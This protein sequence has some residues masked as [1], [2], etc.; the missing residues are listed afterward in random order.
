MKTGDTHRLSID[1]QNPKERTWSTINQQTEQERNNNEIKETMKDEV[2]FLEESNMNLLD[3]LLVSQNSCYVLTEELRRCQQSN[4]NILEELEACQTANRILREELQRMDE[5]RNRFIKENKQYKKANNLLREEVRQLKS[6]YQRKRHSLKIIRENAKLLENKLENED[7]SVFDKYDDMKQALT[8][9]VSKTDDQDDNMSIHS[10]SDSRDTPQEG[11]QASVKSKETAWNDDDS[12]QGDGKSSTISSPRDTAS[13]IPSPR[14]TAS[15]ASSPRGIESLMSSPRSLENRISPRSNTNGVSKART[16]NSYFLERE[17][18]YTPYNK[19]R[20]IRTSTPR[21]G[22]TVSGDTSENSNIEPTG[23]RN[24][25]TSCEKAIPAQT[26]DRQDETNVKSTEEM[27]SD[28]DKNLNF[29]YK[30]GKKNGL[31]LPTI[32]IDNSA[33]K[34]ETD[35]NNNMNNLIPLRMA[36]S[37]ADLFSNKKINKILLNVPASNGDGKMMVSYPR[38]D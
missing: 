24:I 34:E 10:N 6:N 5:N 12:G 30:K 25:H 35:Q 26:L 27:K 3:E 19:W 31:I 20:D 17:P 15:P 23:K 29:I 9:I 37:T 13:L 32:V 22:K 8:N 7:L 38:R 4:L 36:D 28:A 33:C 14:D 18:K 21:N 2:A 11:D 1:L 16:S